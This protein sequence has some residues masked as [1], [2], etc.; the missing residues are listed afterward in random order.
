MDFRFWTLDFGV[1][2]K[3]IDPDG[4]VVIGK[5][6]ASQQGRILDLEFCISDF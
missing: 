1:D 6:E 2:P 4:W 5:K 3:K